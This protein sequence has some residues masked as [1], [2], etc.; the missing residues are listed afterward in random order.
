MSTLASK[1]RGV[2]S[3]LRRQ[4]KA[5]STINAPVTYPDLRARRF[6]AFAIALS[7]VANITNVKPL[8]VVAGVTALLLSL[9]HI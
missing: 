5:A 1:G 3:M 2:G 8:V 6:M 4:R 7:Q 9:I